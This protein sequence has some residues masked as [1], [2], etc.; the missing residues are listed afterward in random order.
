[1]SELKLQSKFLL[2]TFHI[3][4]INWLELTI[5]FAYKP[6]FNPMQQQTHL[7]DEAV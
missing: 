7:T 1:M 5:A 6:S 3:N 2:L 4:R